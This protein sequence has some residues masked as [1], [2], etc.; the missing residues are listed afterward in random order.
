MIIIII[1]IFLKLIRN[2]SL[3]AISSNLGLYI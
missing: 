2:Y 3:F 1:I